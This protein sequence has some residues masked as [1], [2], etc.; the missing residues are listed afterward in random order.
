[1][2]CTAVGTRSPQSHRHRV[3][4][5]QF[6]LAAG[7]WANSNLTV[8]LCRMNVEEEYAIAGRFWLSEMARMI[9]KGCKVIFIVS[10]D[11]VTNRIEV[12]LNQVIFNQNSSKPCLIPIM[13]NCDLSNIDERLRQLLLPYV[14]LHHYDSNL[15]NRL[16]KAVFDEC[17][18]D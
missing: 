12:I 1:M 13:F 14:L 8:M 6:G 5:I 9:Q 2:Y 16:K 7:E 4:V 15:Y 18:R 17:A 10:K 3:H 11:I